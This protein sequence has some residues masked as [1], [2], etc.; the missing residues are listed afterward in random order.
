MA[1]PS[2]NDVILTAILNKNDYICREPML[3]YENEEGGST[4]QSNS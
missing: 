1:L 3:G 4:F 2:N